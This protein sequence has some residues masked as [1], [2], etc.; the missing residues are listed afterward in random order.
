[1]EAHVLWGVFKKFHIG[2]TYLLKGSI[3]YLVHF[4]NG[5]VNDIFFEEKVF[6]HLMILQNNFNFY[7]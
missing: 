5:M 3:L 6:H 1:M 2:C 4:K 7:F